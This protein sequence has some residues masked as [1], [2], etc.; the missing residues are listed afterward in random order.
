VRQAGLN[1]VVVDVRCFATRNALTLRDDLSKSDSTVS[2]VEFGA[3]ENYILILHQD[4]PFISDIYLSEK[5]RNSLLD[6][7][8]S[9]ES[10]KLIS[11]RFSMQVLQMISSYQLKY[12]IK[13][14]DSIL[15]SST[16][17][18]I[19]RI[20]V[21]FNESM[22]NINVEV[23]NPLMNVK[24]PENLVEKSNAELNSSIFSSAL[25]LATR[26][27]DVFGY[28]EYVTGTNNINLLP[29]REN[30][31]NKEKMKF[32]SRWG[33]VA[34]VIIAISLGVWSF[35]VSKSEV[36]RVDM[37]L[38]EY[39]SLIV[40]RNEKQLELDDLLTKKNVL[41]GTLSATKNMKS[42]Q[43]F[44][45]LVLA[46]INNSIPNAYLKL[47]K[48]DFNGDVDVTI[49]GLSTTDNNILSF[50]DNLSKVEVIEKASLV[51]MSIEIIMDQSAKSFTIKCTLAEQKTITNKEDANGN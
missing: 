25:G 33:V 37:L 20:L 3:F 6:N 11:S 38:F 41:A 36:E 7:D 48:I 12:K 17:P 2:I 24:V 46:G 21:H 18:V 4:S 42:N 45:Y 19:D 35:L 31:K 30:V 26:K 13:P 49:Y 14:I 44:M 5:D 50:I 1:P 51:T 34:L 43:E 15:I 28:Y 39:N 16:I 8:V 23:F 27:L 29:N 40:E 22:P 10:L 32:L 9:E 47:S